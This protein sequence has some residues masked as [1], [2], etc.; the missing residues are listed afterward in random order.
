MSEKVTN[1][2]VHPRFRPKLDPDD[3]NFERDQYLRW[4]DEGSLPPPVPVEDRDLIDDTHLDMLEQLEERPPDKEPQMRDL[5]IGL[6]VCRDCKF[7]TDRRSWWRRFFLPDNAQASDL[8]CMDFPR[9]RVRNPITG[10]EGY[11]PEGTQIPSHA[12]AAEPVAPCH[13]VNPTG[14]CRYF[15]VKITYR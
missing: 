7:V 13:S 9:K 11:L 12:Q 8:F 3:P 4:S 2:R 5:K 15:Q 1:I 10:R 6:S 14:T